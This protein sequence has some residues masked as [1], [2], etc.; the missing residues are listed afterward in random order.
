[1]LDQTALRT[2]LAHH[3]DLA[4]SAELAAAHAG[5][6]SKMERV[7]SPPDW[8]IFA[9][10]VVAINTL[11]KQR[12]AVILAHNYMTPEIYHGI[13]DVVGDSLQLAIEATKVEADVIVQ[14]GVHFM[15]ETSKILNPSKTVLIPD[16]EAGCSLA[17]SI[18]ADG[19]SQMR[20]K[21]PG[22]PVVTYV[23]TTA[24]VK[25]ASDICC[26]SSN[27]AQI[28]AAQQ[29]DTVIMTPDKYLAQN[30][31][32]QVPQKRIV[33]WDGACIVHERFTPQDLNDFR[34]Y[35]PDTRIIAHPEC[36]P[37]V[38]EAADFS[39]STSGIIAYVERERPAKAMLVTECSMASNISDSLPDVDFVGPCNMC[40]YMKKIT[41]EKVLWTL[42]TMQGAVEVDA[43]VAD[44]ARIAV[45]RM[46]DLSRQLA[47]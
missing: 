7:I 40:P 6:Y 42:H 18:T 31:A 45:E 9:P 44:K 17:E 15:A 38:V 32:R 20:A 12:N 5:I 25:A 3:Y 46:I 37:D 41:L 22:A 23:N 30:V 28:V 1:M 8:A 29:S 35:N 43:A 19:I 27:A 2:E 33:W 11:K 10:Y 4:P 39:G 36:P 14:C 26:T 47:C 34:T 16:M 24:E 21:Y 13:A